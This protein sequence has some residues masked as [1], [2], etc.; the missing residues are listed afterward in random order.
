MG[1][2]SKWLKSF[3]SGKKDKENKSTQNDTAK[4][5]TT[6]VSSVPKEKRRWSFRRSSATAAQATT[7]PPSTTATATAAPAV[8]NSVTADVAEIDQKKNAMAVA[9]AT[10]AAEDAAVTAAIRFSGGADSGGTGSVEE[11]AAIKIQS[12]FRSYLV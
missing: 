5:P 1:K 2:T 9:P 4:P 6:V 11:A 12:V 10:E 7:T 8:A 3:L